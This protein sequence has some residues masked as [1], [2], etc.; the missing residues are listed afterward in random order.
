VAEGGGGDFYEEVVRGEGER[1]SGDAV[2]G[3]GFVE[4]EGGG[5]EC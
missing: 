1:G 4:L 3:V 2:D 5:G